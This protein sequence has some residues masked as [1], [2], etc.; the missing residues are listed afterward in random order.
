V[1]KCI[2][3]VDPLETLDTVHD[4]TIE[5]AEVLSE[6]QRLLI[7]DEVHDMVVVTHN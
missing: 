2:C 4:V 3:I 6:E 7:V 5:L 1:N